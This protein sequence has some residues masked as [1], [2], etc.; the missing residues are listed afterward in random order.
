MT[1]HRERPSEKDFQKWSKIMDALLS[2]PLM[3]RSMYHANYLEEVT[4]RR[5]EAQ[6]LIQFEIQNNL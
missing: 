6:E 2:I 3:D 5:N 4:Q 1:T